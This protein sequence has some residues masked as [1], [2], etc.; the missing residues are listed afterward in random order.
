[1]SITVIWLFF[2]SFAGGAMAGLATSDAHFD[3]GVY[4][5]SIVAE[6]DGGIWLRGASA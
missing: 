1:M 5:P 3:A 2:C 4:W 6:R